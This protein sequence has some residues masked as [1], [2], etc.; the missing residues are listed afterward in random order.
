[1]GCAGSLPVAGEDVHEEK[2]E[3]A[4]TPLPEADPRRTVHA[5]SLSAITSLED[6]TNK[7]RA[8]VE[9]VIQGLGGGKRYTDPLWSPTEDAR[10]ILY[11]DEDSGALD[12]TVT[13]PAR[14]ERLSTLCEAPV[15]ISN[16]MR[17][18]DV[19]QGSIGDCHLL[20]AIASVAAANRRL[21]RDLFVHHDIAKGVYGVRL[22]L[23]GSWSYVLV[24]DWVAIDEEGEM[25][26]AR[27]EA[28][29]EVWLPVLEKAIAK[30]CCC[31]ENLDG[32]KV[33][34]ALE[35]LTG[36]LSDPRD[37]LLVEHTAAGDTWRQA[38]AFLGRGD[39]CAASTYD[40]DEFVKKGF[41]YEGGVFGKAGEGV[42]K[43]GLV[44]GH[45]YALLSVHE[46]DGTQLYRLRNPWGSGEWNGAWSDQSKQMDEAARAALGAAVEDDGIF[47]M[48]AKDF[49]RYF[50][51]VSPVRLWDDA[52]SMA[53][54][55]GYFL[56]GVPRTVATRR[57]KGEDRDDLSLQRGEEIFLTDGL[58][59]T[60]WQGYKVTD[61]N[62]KDWL[63]REAKTDYYVDCECVELAPGVLP[64][65]KFLLT[66]AEEATEAIVVLLQPD[67]H[68]RRSYKH[69]SKH[70]MHV[71][72][73]GYSKI[74]LMVKS[75]DESKEV[76]SDY[77]TGRAVAVTVTLG[78]TT[79]RVVSIAEY[80]GTGQKYGLAVYSR[81]PVTITPLSGSFEDEQNIAIF[82]RFDLNGQRCLS[83]D[84]I[85]KVLLELGML[86]ASLG[87]AEQR[88]LIDEHFERAVLGA[89]AGA[90]PGAGDGAASVS[91]DAFLKWHHSLST[92]SIVA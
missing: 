59:N 52:W 30:A 82:E 45:V 25:L 88:K 31:F 27:C 28:A 72:D 48:C 55:R 61:A 87:A 49:S 8:A 37:L 20:S 66:A 81:S 35:L 6:A 18:I 80:G 40:D 11:L 46:Y 85:G 92:T 1:M 53:A 79:P 2:T 36:G 63:G 16:R 24:D 10:K 78:P 7:C 5:Q 60:M 15:L 86:D 71:K 19:R 3:A 73:H 84:E 51:S 13:A 83:R 23:N 47:F 4:T 89:E 69:S 17:A 41:R 12:C 68:S 65:L 54:M 70:G 21:L 34:W 57:V 38:A 64:P 44:G 9:A 14:W 32:G 74:H 91:L 58:S 50:V 77:D 67:V 62:K 42:L 76:T 75:A 43:C 29:N 39:V 26:Y 22:Y 90:D 56:R 33:A